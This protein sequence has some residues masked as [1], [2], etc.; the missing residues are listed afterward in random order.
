[1]KTQKIILEQFKKKDSNN[2]VNEYIYF[3]KGVNLSFILY[4]NLNINYLF[5]K[6]LLLTLLK[7]LGIKFGYNCYLSCAKCTRKCK[8]KNF[9]SNN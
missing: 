3:L 8:L 7:S 6:I 4:S 2:K 9:N 1:M 5:E